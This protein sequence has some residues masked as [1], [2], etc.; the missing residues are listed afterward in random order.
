MELD[1]LD[2]LERYFSSISK[3]KGIRKQELADLLERG[4]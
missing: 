2:A 1:E 3:V 4:K